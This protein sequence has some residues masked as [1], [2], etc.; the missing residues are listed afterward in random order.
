VLIR[1]ENRILIVY[2]STTG[3]TRKYADI[4]EEAISCTVMDYRRVT[5]EMLSDYDTVVYGSRA[6]A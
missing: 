3:F 4:V 1:M 5:K 6:H 2:K